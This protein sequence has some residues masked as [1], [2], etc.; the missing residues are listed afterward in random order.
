MRKLAHIYR[1]GLKEVTSLRYDYVLIIFIIYCFTAEVIIPA[2]GTG[3]HLRNASIAVVNEDGSQLA[4]KIIDALQPP[5]FKP[6][7]A[8]GIKDIDLAMERGLYTFIVDIPPDFQKKLLAGRNPEIQVNADGTAVGQA[9]TGVTYL[10][11]IIAREV[12][13]FV[14]NHPKGIQE[15][16]VQVARIKFNPN[17]ESQWFTGLMMLINM[18]TTLSI[19]L[20]A[21][22]LL[23][24]K[25]HGTV[26]HLLVMP[27]NPME[28]MF[29]KIWANSLVVAVGA[30][31]SLLLMVR[32]VLGAPLIGSL[33]LFLLGTLVYLF[34]TTGLGILLATIT[35]N[36]PQMGLLS[37][38]LI[39]PIVML[40]GGLTPK[41]AMPEFLQYFMTLSPT[42]H[43]LD[44]A[45]AVLFRGAGIGAVWTSMAA[46]AVTG[47]VVFAVVIWR[48]R[49]TFR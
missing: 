41:E 4:D 17:L 12:N 44:F 21:A 15:P 43:Y 13:D 10:R 3:F 46:V 30:M 34:A 49:A 9:N 1:L 42:G 37:L 33:M 38:P 22:A 6:P 19:I 7:Q 47:V 11:K 35:Q 23:R 36:S 20:P 45:N 27:L 24:E 40:S 14:R 32:G 31:L 5:Q 39:V 48:F 25:E 2:K 28:I 8:L 16:V 26:E 18:I 29:S